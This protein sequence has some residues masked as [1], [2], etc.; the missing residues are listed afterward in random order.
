M[1]LFNFGK[2]R[3]EEKRHPLALAIADALK[4]KSKKLKMIAA[5]RQKT[6][7]AA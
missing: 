2:K 6:A 4:V 5:L 1:S 3:E 7:F